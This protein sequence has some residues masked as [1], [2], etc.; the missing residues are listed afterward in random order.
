[1]CVQGAL[2]TAQLMSSSWNISFG[3]LNMSHEFH[4]S[5]FH[6]VHHLVTLEFS[7]KGERVI[8]L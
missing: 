2:L 3:C 7:G 5:D 8:S 6:T 1:M 4:A